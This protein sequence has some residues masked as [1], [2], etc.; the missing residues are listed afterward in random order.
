M[1]S[2]Q[3]DTKWFGLLIFSLKCSTVLVG[4]SFAM[5]CH[6]LLNAVRVKWAVWLI[7]ITSTHAR[8]S[9]MISICRSSA[10]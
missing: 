1:Q 4:S 3:S 7:V 6:G 10:R 2:L 9:F 8:K 5:L